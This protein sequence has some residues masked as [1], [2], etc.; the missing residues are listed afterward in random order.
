[1]YA[2]I[3]YA[4]NSTSLLLNGRKW[5]WFLHLNAINQYMLLSSMQLTS[6]ACISNAQLIC[7]LLICIKYFSK[8]QQFMIG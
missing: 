3:Q 7:V 8:L 4:I 2:I 1:M 6:I 5:E